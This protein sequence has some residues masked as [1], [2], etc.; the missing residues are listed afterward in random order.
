L[1][2][3]SPFRQ[4]HFCKSV[5]TKLPTTSQKILDETEKMGFSGIEVRGLDGK[6]LAEEI[7]QFFPENKDAPLA[8]LKAHNL[9][10]VGFGSSVRFDPTD[11]F[12]SMV[13][14][15][16]RAIDVCAFSS[17]SNNFV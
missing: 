16:N 1:R 2:L 8:T 3:K 9:E 13:T 14:K 12:D 10:M 4:T 7:T 6:M 17:F 11:Q 5:S 15:G